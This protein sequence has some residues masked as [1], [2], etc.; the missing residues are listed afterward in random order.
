MINTFNYYDKKLK[1]LINTKV[2]KKNKFISD[3]VAIQ[4]LLEK[5]FI[6]LLI[7]NIMSLLEMM[8]IN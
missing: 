6:K 1:S 5:R 8:I 7:L 3:I 4:H 2:L